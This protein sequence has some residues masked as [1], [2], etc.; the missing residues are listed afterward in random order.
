M[1]TPYRALLLAGLAVTLS[2]ACAHEKDILSAEFSKCIKQSE[3]TNPGML[4]CIGVETSRQDKRLNDAYKKL[5]AELDPERKKQ[6][7]EV[8]RMWIQYTEANCNFHLDPNG[9]TAARL[10]ANECPMLSKAAR[11]AELEGFI[12]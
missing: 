11:A 3:G 1:Y 9:G 6:L 12:Q 7:Q 2:I 4:D 10:S 5:M 8:Q